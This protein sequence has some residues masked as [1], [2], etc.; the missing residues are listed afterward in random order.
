ETITIKATQTLSGS[1]NLDSKEQSLAEDAKFP[2]E[3]KSPTIFNGAAYGRIIAIAGGTL[4]AVTCQNSTVGAVDI[5][6]H[7]SFVSRSIIH[8]N[9]RAGS[10]HD[11]SAAGVACYGYTTT[12]D[13]SKFSNNSF[14]NSPQQSGAAVSGSVTSSNFVMTINNSLFINNNGGS[15]SAGAIGL[16]RR[17]VSNVDNSLFI[18]NTGG[19]D[20]ATIYRHSGSSYATVN[21][22]TIVNNLGNAPVMSAINLTNSIIWG[23]Q[24]GDVII[25]NLG[26]S[27]SN[28]AVENSTT[29]DVIFNLH[30]DNNHANG[31]NF[32]DPV[33]ND[34]SLTAL[35]PMIDQAASENLSADSL[36]ILG[37]KRQISANI[38][39]G[40]GVAD[41]GAY[42]YIFTQSTEPVINECYENAVNFAPPVFNGANKFRYQV[43]K[44]LEFTEIAKEGTTDN[45][46]DNFIIE[47]LFSFIT[48]QF[49][50]R[51]CAVNAFD[52]NISNWSEAVTIILTGAQD[53]VITHE[54]GKFAW[55]VTSED[56]VALYEVVDANGNVIA[57]IVP[58]GSLNYSIDADGSLR[59]VITDV[60]GN[61]QTFYP[62]RDNVATISLPLAK[63]WNLIA[64]P[65]INAD[66]KELNRAVGG[67]YW[68]WN[69]S[70]YEIMP[71]QPE[72]LTGF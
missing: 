16:G 39:A 35:S 34:F 2:W 25:A 12:I 51:V 32:L 38:L 63:G 37:N 55:T 19:G 6:A 28:N 14:T 21:N 29:S 23:N 41:I 40:F 30:G 62:D 26:T 50:L 33:N 64:V 59:L 46:S 58:N 7:D 66:L 3:F 17:G 13:K 47:N 10:N 67:T 4:D 5:T 69:G 45:A 9:S 52:V 70:N 56:G 43:S 8:N 68:I 44:N 72:A 53:V 65:F 11:G 24:T 20:G 1:W 48:N 61:K 18:A 60:N 54:D 42:E 31:P 49:Y 27:S 36:D 57:T 22:S 71:N 15:A